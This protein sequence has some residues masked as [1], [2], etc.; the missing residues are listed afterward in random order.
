MRASGIAVI[1]SVGITSGIVSP[2][3]IGRI[4]TATGSMDNALYIL[5][6]LI[7]LSVFVLLAAVRKRAQETAA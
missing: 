2:W 4:K 6:A 3:A 7:V 5:S 1:S